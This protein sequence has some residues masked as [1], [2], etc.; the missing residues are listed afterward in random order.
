MGAESDQV[1]PIDAYRLTRGHMQR[2][3]EKIDEATKDLYCAI[4][5][6]YLL[7]ADCRRRLDLPHFPPPG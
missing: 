6:A 3:R 7:L 4:R 1:V 2:E 5:T